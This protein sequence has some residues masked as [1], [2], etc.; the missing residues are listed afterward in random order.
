MKHSVIGILLSPDN[1][2]VLL[3]ERRDVPV[4]VLPGGGLEEG[5]E[6]G[7]C[8]VREL[9]EETGLEVAIKRKVGDFYPTNWLTGQTAVFVCELKKETK[10]PL[11]PQ[12][13]SKRVAFHS[14]DNLPKLFFP[15]HKEW[16][17]I[18]LQNLPNPVSQPI[19]SIG[20]GFVLKNLVLHP[21]LLFRYFLARVGLPINSKSPYDG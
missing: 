5:E 7:H 12:Q 13:E 18:A 16:L 17:D 9:F 21:L 20:L 6:A 19:Q 10:K 2:S 1:K 4:W 11:L 3:I 14:L 15:L 8:C